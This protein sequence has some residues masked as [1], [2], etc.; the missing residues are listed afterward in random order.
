MQQNCQAFYAPLTQDI[1]INS[2]KYVKCITKKDCLCITAPLEYIFLYLCLFAAAF[3]FGFFLLQDH[4]TKSPG[5]KH[6]K[7]CQTTVSRRDSWKRNR[8]KVY[9]RDRQRHFS[10]LPTWRCSEG[11]W[12]KAHWGPRGP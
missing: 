10:N 12:K 1:I 3:H 2:I 4:L 9:K 5:G 7:I 8:K 6:D 11:R